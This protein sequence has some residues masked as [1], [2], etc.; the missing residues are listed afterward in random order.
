MFIE[1]SQEAIDCC[2]NDVVIQSLLAASTAMREGNHVVCTC[3][4]ELAQQI[5]D[6]TRETN[7]SVARAFNKLKESFAQIAAVKK[8]ICVYINICAGNQISVC[9]KGNS[10]VICVGIEQ[11]L[12]SDFWHETLLILENFQDEKPYRILYEACNIHNIMVKWEP[13]LGGGTTTADVVEKNVNLGKLVLC[14]ADGDVH[15]PDSGIGETARKII[16]KADGHCLCRVITTN[17]SEVENL[18]FDY[19]IL[20]RFNYAEDVKNQR[21]ISCLDKA[22]ILKKDILFY[23]DVKKGHRYKNIKDNK[24]LLDAFAMSIDTCKNRQFDGVCKNCKECQ[25]IVVEDMGKHY[26]S[27]LLDKKE[28]E[29]QII[30]IFNSF[31]D[32]LQEEW[33]RIAIELTS[34][35]CACQINPYQI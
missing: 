19:A 2:S 24:Y 35:C 14:V 20:Y 34:W 31:S 33:K 26:L 28:A 6:L 21:I 27:Q 22:L 5:V 30:A 12:Y 25:S 7:Q 4:A 11:T 29:S 32:L 16:Q 1:Y 8:Y 10:R 9:Q 18:F 23:Y 15:S 13:V 3:H 17:C